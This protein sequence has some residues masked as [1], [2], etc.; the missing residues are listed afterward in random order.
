MWKNPFW[1]LTVAQIV[2]FFLKALGFIGLTWGQTFT[3]T[4]AMIL[5]I[6]TAMLVLQYFGDDEVKK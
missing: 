1:L 2:M 3:P 5:L 6:S 4:L